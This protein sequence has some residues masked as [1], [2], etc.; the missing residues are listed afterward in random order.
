MKARPPKAVCL[1]QSRISGYADHFLL[2]Q[3]RAM[4]DADLVLRRPPPE[5]LVPLSQLV[6]P[7]LGR[8][9][10]AID[11]TIGR[12]LNAVRRHRGQLRLIE[13]GRLRHELGRYRVVYAMFAWEAIPILRWLPADSKLVVHCAGTDI[14]AARSRPLAYQRGLSEVFRRAHHLNCGSEFIRAKALDL[15]APE[16]KTSV[17]YL[18]V[19]VPGE[20]TNPR[21]ETSSPRILAV[22]RLHPVKGIDH[23]IA[24]FAIVSKSHPTAVLEIIGDGPELAKLRAQVDDLGLA[25]SV[26]FRGV[27]P[28]AQVFEAM[29]KADVFVQHNVQLAN[30]AEEALGGS[31]L[32]AS[33]R[34]LPVV[35]TRSGGVAEAVLDGVTGLL[36]RPGDTMAMAKNLE[37][38]LRSAE[39]R[40]I[41]GEAGREHVRRH[42]NSAVQTARLAQQLRVAAL[43]DTGV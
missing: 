13:G 19:D 5:A 2:D 40:K 24:S 18:G 20:V 21:R 36:S 32:E 38:V 7:Q 3:L 8:A 30:G 12:A 25:D 31:I 22:A 42:H 39:L 43:D 10:K 11:S 17:H 16:A 29:G 35:A 15:G 4:P 27:L 28:R 1:Y 41:L 23:T 14:T 26:T 34:G 33:A 37:A 9:S 6:T